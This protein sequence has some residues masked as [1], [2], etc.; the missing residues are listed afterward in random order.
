[1]NQKEAAKRAYHEAG[2]A[3]IARMLGLKVHYVTTL[4]SAEAALTHC[5]A[6]QAR[7]ADQVTR[8]AAFMKD[9]IVALAGPQA[10][11]KYRPPKNKQP[12]EWGDDLKNAQNSAIQ[13]ALMASG[14]DTLL[15]PEGSF[16]TVDLDADQ[17]VC[18]NDMLQ[19]ARDAVRDLVAEH[20]P[21]IERVAAA[22]LSHPILNGDDLDELI[23]LY[24]K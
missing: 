11:L 9:I 23:V 7:N 14:V 10:Q 22:L 17:A 4:E 15:N 5:A 6:Y 8:L 3:V 18:A 24:M 13:A 1:M 16:I 19:Q 21:Q 12:Y 20:W 2:H